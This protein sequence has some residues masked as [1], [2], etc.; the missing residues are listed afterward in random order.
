MTPIRKVDP[1]T[2]P[3]AQ[4]CLPANALLRL[5]ICTWFLKAA[6]LPKHCH[7]RRQAR[8][9][10]TSCPRSPSQGRPAVAIYGPTDSGGSAPSL[11]PVARVSNGAKHQVCEHGIKIKLKRDI[12]GK[13][14]SLS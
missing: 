12:W 1:Q 10:H 6:C 5:N 9:L 4:G 14:A 7:N 3:A 2:T 11:E 8:E 13:R